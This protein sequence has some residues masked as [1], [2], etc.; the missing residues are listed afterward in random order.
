MKHQA[1]PPS[2]NLDPDR[3]PVSRSALLLQSA[4]EYGPFLIAAILL[5]AT[6]LA[7][8]I[9]PLENILPSSRVGLY[10]CITF[11]AL[12]AFVLRLTDRVSELTRVVGANTET[13]RRFISAA[14]ESTTRVSLDQAFRMAESMVSHCDKIRI[15][16]ISSK[17]I[18]QLMI[19]RFT[20]IE[21]E[22]L[23]G[24]AGSEADALLDSEVHLS[25]L[26]T[27][28]TRVRSAAIG[29]LTVRQYDFYPTEW[30]VL[31][32]DRLMITGSYV[33]DEHEIGRTRTT[34]TAYVVRADDEGEQLIASKLEAF[35][36]L[37]AASERHFSSGKYE[38]CYRL[39][40][41]RVKKL[42]LNSLEWHELGPLSQ[43]ALPYAGPPSVMSQS[44]D[45]PTA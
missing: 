38:G 29:S 20:A 42:P 44:E 1:A 39:I 6:S 23:L 43:A 4:L 21:M 41:G 45:Q 11:L 37:F 36:S 8:G 17:F 3:Q 7:D 34:D 14:T 26:Y 33:F 27:W 2:R 28:V 35:D 19:T 22:L 5:I 30:Y 32:D 13:Q 12:L 9:P 16:A 24:A 15:Y 31:F 40:E 18:S 25:V 10:V